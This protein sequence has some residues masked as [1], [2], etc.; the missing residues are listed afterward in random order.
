[1]DQHEAF[2]Q[3]VV[4][5]PEDDAPRLVYADWLD[6]QGDSDRA[7]F[8]RLQCA[9]AKL[10]ADAPQR[11]AMHQRE[12]ELLL[13]HSWEWAAGFGWRIQVWQ[14]VR[15]FI[16]RVETSLETSADEIREVLRLGP[17]RH[18]RDTGQFCDFS[19]VVELLPSFDR[20]TGLEFWGLYAFDDNLVERLLSS[21]HLAGLRT[22]VLH[23]DRNGNM[24][25]DGVLCRT[26]ALPHWANL[27]TL[28]VNV[29]STWRGMSPELLDVI[30]SSP[31]L[32]HLRRL[33]L[34]SA[35]DAGHEPRMTPELMRRLVASP[36][37][38]GL[39]ELDLDWCSFTAEAW[40]VLL[41]APW[42]KA[43]ERLGLPYAR[44]ITAEREHVGYLGEMPQWRARLQRCA[45]R[46]DFEWGGVLTWRGQSWAG[47][48]QRHLFAM[49]PYVQRG[50]LDALEAAYREDCRKFAGEEAAA[51]IDAVPFGRWEREL[52]PGLQQAIATA[53]QESAATSIFLRLRTD[54]RWWG[55]YHVSGEALRE[56]FV[57]YS[58]GG[59][60]GPLASFGSP[61]LPEAGR[62]DRRLLG[63]L[64]PGGAAHYLL[65]RTVA[66]FARCVRTMPSPVPVFL[67]LMSAVFRMAQPSEGSTSGR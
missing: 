34:S 43:M 24:V 25:D 18:L 20:L 49:W 52:R 37:L 5:A 16:E 51:A 14:F 41:A 15:G 26:M 44:I 17:I 58:S 12:E 65:A 29:D 63:P 22:L 3:A 11:P 54:I 9:L 67:D 59:Y 60:S 19:G 47:L 30:A 31:H 33:D 50:D 66:A 2:L 38:A 32:R 23:H 7:E 35:A 8:I 57:P 53:G 45:A 39:K 1:M 13:L 6:E 56:P 62:V 55:E 28:A 21:P 36:N 10:P 48:R 4:E 61:E 40:E 42:F 46:V 27:R 64:D